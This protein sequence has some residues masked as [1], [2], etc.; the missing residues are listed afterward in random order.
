MMSLLQQRCDEDTLP[1]NKDKKN[2]RPRKN[3][4][5]K[6]VHTRVHQ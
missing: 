4:R 3:E 2:R 1:R 6:D 5:K